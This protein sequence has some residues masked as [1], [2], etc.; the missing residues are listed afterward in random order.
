MTDTYLILWR[1]IYF[2]LFITKTKVRIEIKKIKKRG[3]KE[4][5]CSFYSGGGP[6][7]AIFAGHIPNILIVRAADQSLSAS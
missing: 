4:R 3:E 7:I 5:V 6:I 1:R 2:E